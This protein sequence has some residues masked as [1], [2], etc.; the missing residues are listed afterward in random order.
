MAVNL[1]KPSLTLLVEYV[2]FDEYVRFFDG[3]IV[4]TF[5]DGE[6]DI[7]QQSQDFFDFVANVV[8]NYSSGYDVVDNWHELNE[9]FDLFESMDN[10][11]KVLF[12]YVL[13]DYSYS[14]DLPTLTNYCL[15]NACLFDGSAS[16][17][18]Y[19]LIHDCYNVKSMGSLANYI[20][21]ESFACD[22]I[23][24][25]DIVELGYNL[26]WTNPGDIY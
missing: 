10:N 9:C 23:C 1:I 13:A 25:G 26:Y 22:L 11:Q 2:N 3:G 7:V 21:Y 6:L 20:D 5:F 12:A 24:G 8:K 18:A 15:E 14:Y 16:D 17:Y 4:H 19:E